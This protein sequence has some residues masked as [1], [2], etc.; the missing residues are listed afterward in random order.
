MLYADR[1]PE[2]AEAIL[3]IGLALAPLVLVAVRQ[4]RPT[5]R[6]T[7]PGILYADRLVD[8]T[9]EGIVLRHYYYPAGAK[10]VKFD[11][12]EYIE[13]RKLTAWTGGWRI[14]GSGD[15]RTWW[16]ADLNRP[17]RDTAFLLVRK[18]KWTRI[19]FTVEDPAAVREVL[20]SVG[21]LREGRIS[22]MHNGT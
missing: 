7:G 16:P 19:A 12:A 4:S 5:Q 1:L 9:S 11:E 13:A 6:P 10:R 14:W 8:I 3:L 15:F 21:V 2:V 17:S 22:G 18:G 20:R